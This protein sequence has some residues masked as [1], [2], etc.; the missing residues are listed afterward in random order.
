MYARVERSRESYKPDCSQVIHMKW[1]SMRLCVQS[2]RRLPY[3]TTRYPS[4]NATSL[5][6]NWMRIFMRT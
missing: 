2:A 1:V 3:T 5:E 6:F 4:V